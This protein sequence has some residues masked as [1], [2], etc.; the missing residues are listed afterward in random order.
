M[1]DSAIWFCGVQASWEFFSAPLIPTRCYFSATLTKATLNGAGVQVWDSEAGCD[2]I[3]Q[4]PP[5]SSPPSTIYFCGKAEVQPL[6]E[7][8]IFPTRCYYSSQLTRIQVMS[9]GVNVYSDADDCTPMCAHSPPPPAPFPPPPSPAAPPP[10][11]GAPPAPPAPPPPPSPPPPPPSPAPLPPSASPTPPPEPSP[12]PSPT[13]AL[14]TLPEE[15]DEAEED[16]EDV[17]DEGAEGDGSAAAVDV[18]TNASTASALRRGGVTPAL[19]LSPLPAP[20]LRA[21][22]KAVPDDG[23]T[24]RIFSASA[25]PPLLLAAAVVVVVL[26]A[27]ARTRRRDD[28]DG[29]DDAPSAAAML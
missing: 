9:H 3:P 21:E 19:S 17:W 29:H 12:A 10:S 14:L 7:A 13:P 6:F 27:R 4:P 23:P 1:S 16:S 22:P 28:D 24:D 25:G 8:P 26:A 20:P 15:S 5:P 2:C 18:P 11:P